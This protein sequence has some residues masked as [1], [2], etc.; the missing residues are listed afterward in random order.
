MT[1]LVTTVR[2]RPD[3]PAAPRSHGAPLQLAAVVL[4]VALGVLAVAAAD[5]GSRAGD[6]WAGAAFWIGVVVLFA[7]AAF[8]LGSPRLT[9]AQRLTAVVTLG[10][11]L[12]LVKV[13][14]SPTQLLF[15]DEFAHWR[16]ASNVLTSGHLFAHDPLIPIVAR[17]PGLATVTSGLARLGGVS[18]STAGL[19]VIGAGRLVLLLAL[20]LLVE[21]LTFSQRAPA[22]ACLV[23]MAH[24]NF[25][26]WGA[27]YAYE[28]LA[29]PLALLVVYLVVRLASDPVK[30]DT[31]GLALLTGLAICAVVVTH[32]LTS[33]ALAGTLLAWS[34][35]ATYQRFRAS[36]GYRYVPAVFAAITM[37]LAGCWLAFAAPGTRSY[38]AP[39]LSRAEQQTIAVASGQS[40]G[41]HAFQASGGIAAPVWERALGLA[42]VALLL[43]LLPFGAWRMWRSGRSHPLLPLLTLL[44]LAFPLF[45]L[46][47]LVPDAQE[48]ANRSSEFVYVGLGLAAAS[49]LVTMVLARGRPL[50]RQAV[51]L[52]V[53]LIVFTGGVTTAWSYYSR[54]A[55]RFRPGESQFVT[56]EAIVTANWM[57]STL[58]PNNRVAADENGRNAL[59]SYGRQD[60]VFGANGNV[61]VWAIFLPGTMSEP[62]RHTIRSGKVGYLLV[63]RRLANEVPRN[64]GSY[65]DQGEPGEGTRKRPIPAAALAKFDSV[66]GVSRL[67]DAGPIQVYDVRGLPG[68]GARG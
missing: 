4:A 68:G 46:L 19:I 47:R 48:T 20:Y 5:A 45:L 55:P 51:A 62:V 15:S 66:P 63:D 41:R 60:P 11:G 61:P 28:S 21:R 59:G 40:A 14:Y 12:Y 54:L 50:R 3:A 9:R 42:G 30:Q 49:A 18:I 13:V 26:Y 6:S 27:E 10:M 29:L 24:P 34:I 32:H 17:Y 22:L 23:Y 52:A 43:L 53:L 7:P 2:V 37:A 31:G 33:Y 58:G 65:F 1:P 64:L 56:P 38:I 16:A 36:S 8:V 25:L 67:F 57:R 44:A 35:V 39:V